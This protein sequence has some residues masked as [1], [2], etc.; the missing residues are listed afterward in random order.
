[1]T[2]LGAKF[3]TAI[4][5]RQTQSSSI[6]QYSVI[7]TKAVIAIR[8]LAL[9]GQT[10]ALVIVA[11]GFG[12]EGAFTS[13]FGLVAVGAAVNLWQN[14]RSRYQTVTSRPELLIALS[15]DV[16]QLS[17]L[18][19]L[20]GGMANPF[21]MLLLAPVVVSAALLDFRATVYLVLLVGFCAIM[22]THFY[23][24]LPF[25]EA[26]FALPALYLSGLF[27]ALL[28][29]CVFIGFYV[30]Y[31]ADKA[32]Q[33]NAAL[34]AMQLLLERDRR[35]TVLGSLAA[36]AAHKLGSPLNTIAVISHDMKASLRGKIDSNDEV[37][38]DV[39]LLNDEVERCRTI[40]SEL[41]KDA[42]T[43]QPARDVAL[44]VSQMIQALLNPKLAELGSRVR[45]KAG[46]LDDSPEPMAKPI[47]DLKY[48]LE[49]L[50]DN[51]NDFAVKQ[52]TF[53]T[54]WSQK[55][56]AIEI[57]D[58]GP[59]LTPLV[60]S[61]VGQPWNSSREGREGHKGLGLFL[62][63]TLIEALEGEVKIVNAPAGGGAKISIH[64]SQGSLL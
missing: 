55:A 46:P 63:I 21:A 5:Q 36:A 16:L 32:R 19:Y 35:A 62:A 44:P 61:R 39:S 43:D 59:G 45:F 14:W 18:L 58:D 51:A 38:Q 9:A 40:L 8:W 30:W 49:I 22:V 6:N 47:P 4:S 41:D 2:G 52:I 25:S 37:L 57:C 29:S 60:L 3:R 1:M 23:L 54:S 42:Q 12:Y 11:F 34:A 33:A 50:L 27:T 17:G 31:L 28:V 20:T 24:P 15:F 26:D 7:D 53:I 48:A 64:M 56:I 10:I 13:A